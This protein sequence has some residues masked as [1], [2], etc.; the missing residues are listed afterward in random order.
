MFDYFFELNF[1]VN[2]QDTAT[3][4]NVV[5]TRGWLGY[6]H[7]SQFRETTSN[8][9]TRISSPIVVINCFSYKIMFNYI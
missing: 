7:M 3:W 6:I 5:T 9:M 4:F 8:K 2:A 1:D